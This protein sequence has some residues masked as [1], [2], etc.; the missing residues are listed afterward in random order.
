MLRS[1]TRAINKQNNFSG[2]L[3]RQHTKAECID[4]LHKLTPSFVGN[5]IIISN[6][7]KQYP[8]VC[9]NYIHQNPVKAK[10]VKK[11]E[12][13]E[14]SSAIDF[15]GLRDGSLINRNVAKQYL[16]F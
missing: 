12:D 1:Y 13:W 15:A 5:E 10:L 11:A 9:F 3:F 6:P 7:Q 16:D 14:Y 4:C 8:Q 2:S